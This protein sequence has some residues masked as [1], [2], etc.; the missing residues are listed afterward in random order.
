[1]IAIAVVGVPAGEIGDVDRARSIDVGWLDEA[2]VAALPRQEVGSVGAAVAVEVGRHRT[3][4]AKFVLPKREIGCIYGEIV[5]G[6]AWRAGGSCG[7]LPVEEVG[8]VDHA[9]A[10]E[11]AWRSHRVAGDEPRFAAMIAVKRQVE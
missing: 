4:D 11:I 3:E 1:M 2:S 9:I 5:V 6:I 8:S 7:S 10:I